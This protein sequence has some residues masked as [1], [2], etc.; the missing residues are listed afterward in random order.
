[1]NDLAVAAPVA[2]IHSSSSTT[3]KVDRFEHQF[4]QLSLSLPSM[5]HHIRQFVADAVRQAAIKM[6][7]P[8]LGSLHKQLH[9]SSRSK[10]TLRL[11]GAHNQMRPRGCFGDHLRT[12][13]SCRPTSA[14]RRIVRCPQHKARK[15]GRTVLSS[16]E[17]TR[18]VLHL[19]AREVLR[20]CA[21]A[22]Q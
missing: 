2:A 6:L 21:A 12:F 14:C 22:N 10:T 11:F 1:M 19:Q 17:T 9:L 16:R 13:T 4:T 7:C 20:H 3:D 15:F 18:K 8:I 5:Q